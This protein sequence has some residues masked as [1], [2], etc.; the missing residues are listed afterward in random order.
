MRF[1]VKPG[2][3]TLLYP[4]MDSRRARPHR[5]HRRPRRHQDHRQRP[6]HSM[7]ARRG[8]HVRVPPRRSARRLT[9]DVAA[10]FISPPEPPA[11]PSGGSITSQLAVLSWNQLLLYP[12]GTPSRPTQLSGRPQSSARLALR[13]RAPDRP[14][15]RQPDRVQAVSLTTLDRFARADRRQFQDDRPESRRPAS[16]LPPHRR[17]QRARHAHLGR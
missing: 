7:A 4:E 14:A 5:T 6:A 17:R 9:I 12:K 16:P 8:Q 2:P 10:E 15:N 11:S 13:H 3:F 1:P